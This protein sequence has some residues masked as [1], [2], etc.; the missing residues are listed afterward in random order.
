[1]EGLGSQTLSFMRKYKLST[2]SK[3]MRELMQINSIH[4]KSLRLSS[5]ARKDYTS[6]E[7]VNLLSVDCN[8]VREHSY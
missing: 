1:M 2:F 4:R 3:L 8:R 7:I 6:G 5:V